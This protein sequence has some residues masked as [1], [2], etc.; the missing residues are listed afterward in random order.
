MTG[1]L[2]LISSPVSF[3]LCSRSFS[4]SKTSSALPFAFSFASVSEAA[5]AALIFANR[6]SRRLSSSGICLFRPPQQLFDLFLQLSFC[7]PHPVIA[8]RLV[9]GRIRLHLRPVQGHMTQ[10][11]QP[12][13]PAQSH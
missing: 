3:A 12:R 1:S 11:H 7:L 10:L 5:F 2:P 9:L 4:C 8:H 13:F 6:L